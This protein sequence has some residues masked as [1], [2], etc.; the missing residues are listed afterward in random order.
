MPAATWG[1]WWEQSLLLETLAISSHA[2]H[3]A[4]SGTG[5]SSTSQTP[6]LSD[7]FCSIS[8]T[9]A[10]KS[11]LLLRVHVIRLDHPDKSRTLDFIT[12]ITSVKSLG[13]QSITCLSVPGIRAG[14]CL[15]SHSAYQNGNARYC[16]MILTGNVGVSMYLLFD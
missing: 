5:G 2:S 15:R 8:L 9:P 3:T 10:R 1:R 6:H 13:S 16:Q 7:F 4:P 12:L 14:T 11:S